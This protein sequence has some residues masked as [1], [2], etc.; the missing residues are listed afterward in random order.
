MIDY[1][2]IIYENLSMLGEVTTEYPTNF[3]NKPLIQYSEENNSILNRCIDRSVVKQ[4]IK[5]KIDLWKDQGSLNELSCE[6]DKV[7]DLIGFTRTGCYDVPDPN[8][9]KH[10]QMRYEMYIG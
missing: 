4:Y 10:K 7:M 6:V 9:I 8:G 2:A 3:T 5:F 1:S